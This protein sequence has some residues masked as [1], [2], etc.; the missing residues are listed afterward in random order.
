MRMC[1]ETGF[2]ADSKVI[3]MGPLEQGSF[4]SDV[5]EMSTISTMLRRN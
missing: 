3:F 4:F 5:V 2:L 1:K